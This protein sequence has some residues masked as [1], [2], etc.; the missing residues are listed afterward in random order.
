[1]GRRARTRPLRYPDRRAKL[2]DQNPGLDDQG[3]EVGIGGEPGLG[4]RIRGQGDL[5][6]RQPVLEEGGPIPGHGQADLDEV[7]T[8]RHG[9]HRSLGKEALQLAPGGGRRLANEFGAQP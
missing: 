8:R 7:E 6:S 9:Y 4:L 3:P 2:L 5:A 1:M